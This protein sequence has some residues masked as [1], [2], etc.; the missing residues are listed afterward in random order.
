MQKTGPPFPTLLTAGV[1]TATAMMFPR[2]LVVVGVVSLPLATAVA[3][4]LLS[5]GLLSLCAAAWFVSRA[6][7]GQVSEGAGGPEPSNPLDLK[8]A[9]QFGLLLAAT[10]ILARGA[11]YSMGNRGLYMLAALIGLVDVDSI[12]LSCASM[13]SQGQLPVAAAADAILLATAANTMTKPLIVMKI[14]DMRMGWR[15]MFAIAA[16]LIGGTAGLWAL[17]E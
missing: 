16:I 6:K 8:I 15:V 7:S 10:M 11:S 17:A 4:P 1:A 12:S 2:M 9:V 3:K 13:V 5:A 14:G